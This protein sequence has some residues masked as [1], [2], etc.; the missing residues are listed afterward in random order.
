MADHA[1]WAAHFGAR[2][3]IHEAEATAHQGTDLCEV[4]LGG[5]GPWAFPDGDEDLQIIH[6]PGC[7]ARARAGAA[8]DCMG[9]RWVALSVGWGVGRAAL[10]AC[11]TS[12]PLSTHNP[13]HPQA[14]E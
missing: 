7:D 6:T 12:P 14:H 5:R 2:R 9:W 13:A 8:G 10:P 3:I 4:K 1:K 11:L